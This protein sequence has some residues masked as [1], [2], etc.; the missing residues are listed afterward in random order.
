MSPIMANLLHL[1][2]INEL[3]KLEQFAKIGKEVIVT[4]QSA[5]FRQLQL[6]LL[7]A[8]HFVLQK[9]LDTL[10]VL[11]LKNKNFSENH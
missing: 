9:L 11:L 5:G 2:N 1:Q 10:E 8:Y 6:Q 3:Q 4:A 7:M